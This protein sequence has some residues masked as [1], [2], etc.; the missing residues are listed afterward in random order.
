MPE[1]SVVIR[2]FNEAEY[3]GEVL[4]AVESQ[5]YQNFEIILVDSGSTDGTLEIAEEYVDQIKFVSPKNFTFGH[6]CNL[7][8]EAASGEFVSFLSA[9]AIPTTD[10][11]LGTMIENVREEDV[12]MTY[13]NQVGVEETMLSESRLFNELFP[14]RSRR[15]TPPDY[16]ANNASSVI[17]QELWEDH[18]FDEYLTGHEDIE[19]AKHFM[20][21][22]Y[23]VVYESDA[24]IYHIHDEN[25]DQIF[26]RFEREAIADIEIGIKTPSDRWQE[27]LSIPKDIIGDLFYA[28]RKGE[29]ELET[30][31]NIIKFRY[32]QHMGTASGLLSERDLE[33]TRYKYFY[34]GVNEKVIVNSDGSTVLQRSPLPVVRPNEVLIRTDYIGV[35]EDESDINR[36]TREED[37]I[38][39]KGNYVGTVVDT[40]ANANSINEGDV[41]VGSTVFECGICQACS[42][43]R[44]QACEDPI[45]LGID[46]DIGAYSR[47]LTVPSHHVYQLP[48]NIDKKTGG[49]IRTVSR[50]A[51]EIERA[52]A[53]VPNNEACLVVGDSPHARIAVQI[54]ESNEY[55]VHQFKNGWELDSKTDAHDLS[56]YGLI[57]DI[58]GNEYA[59]EQS[60]LET[61][62]A[63]VLLLLGGN[64]GELTLSGDFSR[65]TTIMS[66]GVSVFEEFERGID[67]I[68][69]IDTDELFDGTYLFEEYELAWRSA[70]EERGF[71]IIQI[72]S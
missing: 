25:W 16:W 55:D 18:H 19:W 67:I 12:A 4:E 33:A 14:E 10:Q 37:P 28:I 46:T 43:G 2:S 50:V 22:G 1:T 42:N 63:T 30:I 56:M 57:V 41:V 3:I 48:E 7:G 59:I 26:N 29:L 54:L 24:C 62:Y 58:T 66:P 61:G 32:N 72:D 9:H 20:D 40:G 23:V 13:S 68:Q 60:V 71:P 45:E 69:D 53:L 70:N 39:P 47:F 34:G 11:W 51:N 64:Y 44:P 31:S 65:A 17:K 27:Y 5:K 8:C 38:V 15:Q 6:S 35:D 52:T 49:L 21:Q 36:I